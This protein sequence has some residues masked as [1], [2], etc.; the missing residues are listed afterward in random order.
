M[1]ELRDGVAE[2][3]SGGTGGVEPAPLT[4]ASKMGNVRQGR[5]E[6]SETG[7]ESTAHP[8]QGSLDVARHDG[9]V[10]TTT[11]QAATRLSFVNHPG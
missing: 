10:V 2:M 6:E 11:S 3:T 8:A 5:N 4:Y 9:L 1:Q 7:R